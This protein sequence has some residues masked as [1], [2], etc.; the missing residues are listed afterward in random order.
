[1]FPVFKIFEKLFKVPSGPKCSECQSLLKES[2]CPNM[3]CPLKVAY[4]IARWCSQAGL[5]IPAIDLTLAK[6]L[7][8]LHLVIHPGE[9][10][11]LSEGDWQRLDD[12]VTGAVKKEAKRQLE[13]SKNAEHTALLYGFRI[14]GVDADLSKRLVETFD[15]ISRLRET[16]AEQL[17]AIEGVDECV[18]VAIHKWFRD[19]FNRKMLKILDRNG[20]RFD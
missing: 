20:F 14:D 17:Q 2:E 5:K 15:R 13:E 3:D 16:K 11:E 7:A 8:R 12:V 6:H 1:M 10:Y 4:W 19:S 18:A 9:L